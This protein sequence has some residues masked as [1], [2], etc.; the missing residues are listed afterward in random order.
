V[1]ESVAKVRRDSGVGVGFYHA[2]RTKLARDRAQAA[3]EQGCT[4]VLVATNAFGMGIE[5]PDVRLIVQ[6]QTPG[7]LEAY[8]QEAGRAGRDGQPAKC[9]CLFGV[10]DLVT[11]R[12]LSQSSTATVIMA[13]RREQALLDIERYATVLSCRHAGLVAHFTDN[14]LEPACT[15]CDVCCGTA[16]P[17][18]GYSDD[19]D[20]VEPEKEIESLD[21]SELLAIEAAVDRLK[22]P[23]GRVQ[24]AKALLGGH[25]KT[26]S[27]GGLKTMP[28]YGLLARYSEESVLAAIDELLKDGKLVRKGGRFPTLWTPG[29]IEPRANNQRSENEKTQRSSATGGS[30]IYALD[31]FRKRTARS[32]GWKP[33]MVLQ[34]KVIAQIDE[35]RPESIEELYAIAGL[36]SA[37]IERFGAD[38][39]AIVESGSA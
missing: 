11:Q 30:L 33:Y 13:A 23:V 17:V 9:L 39:L 7:S 14:S 8:Y 16:I 19:P 12:R 15:R 26:L 5:I 22:R 1:V 10:Q 35:Q 37:K 34:K 38:I 21:S 20:A 3:F 2:G 28:E 29:K 31:R 6:F 18:A 27:R 24:L 25:A 4:R 32:L 36:G